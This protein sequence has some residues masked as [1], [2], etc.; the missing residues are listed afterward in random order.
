MEK[1]N[2]HQKNIILD[3]IKSQK[4][5]F[6]I[7]DIY[8]QVNGKVGLTTIY[9]MIDNLIDENII[10]KYISKDNITYY[11]FLN[12]CEEENHF[13][14]KCDECGDLVHI[15]CDCI[16]DLSNHISKKHK[17]R[18]NKNQIVINGICKKC[19]KKGKQQ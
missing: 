16:T 3:V 13:Y 5:E 19:G 18:L 6:T 14:L 11:L 9:R 2:T 8:N 15:D 1:Y 12:S 7:K 10:N 17:F 4:K